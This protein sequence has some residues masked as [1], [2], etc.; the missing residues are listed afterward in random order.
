MFH[1]PAFDAVR[2]LAERYGVFRRGV[3]GTLQAEKAMWLLNKLKEV[4]S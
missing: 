2:T 4:K 1:I 3:E